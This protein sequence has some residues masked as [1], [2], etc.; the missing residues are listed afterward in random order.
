MM[1]L[2]MIDNYDSFT[3][4]LVQLVK[5]NTPYEVDVYR[6]DEIALSDVESYDKIIISPGPGLPKEAGVLC[7]LIERYQSTKP[8]FGVCLGMQAIAEVTGATLINIDEPLHGVATPIQHA[9][10]NL[11]TGIPEKFTVGR[12]HSW[13]VETNSL[14]KGLN[15]SATDEHGVIMAIEHE[16]YNVSGVQFHPESILTEYGKEIIINFLNQ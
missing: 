13:A 12:Y 5:E 11:F 15:V 8:I 7:E 2:L 9:N 3:Y 16:T 1:K 4:N 10:T 14:P 6:N